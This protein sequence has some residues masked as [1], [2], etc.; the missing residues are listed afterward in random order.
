MNSQ[1]DRCLPKC[2]VKLKKKN[3]CD[4]SLNLKQPSFTFQCKIY[5][6]RL[7]ECTWSVCTEGDKRI[8]KYKIM[9]FQC[10]IQVQRWDKV[11]LSS[12]LSLSSFYNKQSTYKIVVLNIVWESISRINHQRAFIFCTYIKSVFKQHVYIESNVHRKWSK[13]YFSRA[14]LFFCLSCGS[15]RTRA[16]GHQQDERWQISQESCPLANISASIWG[17]VS[18]IL[19]QRQTPFH[20]S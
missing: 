3:K 5:H 20:P 2:A 19:G 8:C 12:M 4:V 9:L 13:K 1:N 14:E 7:F 18:L 11:N 16:S 15:A 17:D 10:C 6:F